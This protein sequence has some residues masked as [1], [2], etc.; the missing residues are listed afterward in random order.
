MNDSIIRLP[1]EDKELILIPTA[2]VSRESVELVRQVIEEEKP[3]SVCIELDNQRYQAMKNPDAWEQTDIVKVIKSKRVGFLVA[4]LAISSYQKRIAKKLGVAVGGEMMQGIKSADE[5]GARL[6]FADRSIQTTFLRIWRSMSM[7]EKVKLI[8]SLLFDK[9]DDGEDLTEDTIQELLQQDVMETVL[10]SLNKEFPKVG[11]I[12]ISERDQYLANKIKNAPGPKVVAVLGGA[13]APGVLDELFREQ[14]LQAISQVPPANKNARML[15]WL[16]PVAIIGLIVYGFVQNTQTGFHQLSL[17]VLWNGTLAALGTLLSLGH[18][19]SI[20]TAFLAAPITS[21]N[22]FL[23][24]GWFAG[25]VE[26][27]VKRPTVRDVQNVPEDIFS[28]KG[29]F[30]NRFLKIILVVLMAN[31]GSSIGTLVAG[32]DMIRNL[33]G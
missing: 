16:L 6:V 24:C 7:W 13:H 9:D 17:W 31:V 22:P 25:L 18:P 33:L 3:D 15:R 32:T 4:Y 12:L 5:I 10:T 23:A 28:L 29:F 2:H 14:D 20:A 30:R 11:Q 26:A 1:Y 8:V 21:L 27:S 19:L